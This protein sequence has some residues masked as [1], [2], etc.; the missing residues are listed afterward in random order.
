MQSRKFNEAQLHD[1]NDVRGELHEAIRH[2]KIKGI[3][4]EIGD[5]LDYRNAELRTREKTERGEKV[6]WSERGA[7][8]IAVGGDK[9]S[10]GLTLDGL[11]ISYYLRSSRMYDTL[12]QMGR[13]FG[14]RD[15]YNDLCRIFTTGELIEWYRHIALADRELKN[16]FD[17]MEAI[18]SSPEKFGLKVRNHPGRLAVTSAGKARATERMM[19]TFAGRCL[20]TIVFDPRNNK[21]NFRALE[22]LV[23][24]MEKAYRE[25]DDRKPRYH[26][27]DVKAD[28][29]LHFLRSYKTQEEFKRVVDPAR[30]ADYIDRQ[31]LKNELTNWHVVI[32]SN[33]KSKAVHFAKVAGLDVGSVQ[34]TP[35]RTNETD[36]ISI[37][38]LTSPDDE[39][40][41]MTEDEIMQIREKF[42]TEKESGEL[43]GEKFA[44]FVMQERSS[45]TGLLLVY[46]PANENVK[47]ADGILNQYGLADNEVVGFAAS[48]PGSDTAEPVEYVVNSVYAEGEA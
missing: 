28:K 27:D 22:E 24:G 36:R 5:T 48:F 32:V 37:G 33:T 41:D 34:R 42:R 30:I 11:S 6:P 20:R 10:R 26:W 39:Y 15:G 14:Y 1:W 7:S 8:L 4:G 3:N 16:E 43:A 17:Y 47:S 21:H 12:M 46:L 38:T 40:L 44:A 31:L 9:L 29:V 25:I 45:E 18:G 2:I 23:Q 35:L 13:W 19:I